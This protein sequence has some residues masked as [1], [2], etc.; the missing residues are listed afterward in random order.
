MMLMEV[1]VVMEVVMM[2]VKLV[3]NDNTGKGECVWG[4][5][6]RLGRRLQAVNGVKRLAGSLRTLKGT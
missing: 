2:A 3:E 4:K 1:V 5:T 6:E